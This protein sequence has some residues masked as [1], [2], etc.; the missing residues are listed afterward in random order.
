MKSLPGIDIDII[1]NIDRA[2]PELL[3]YINSFI[4]KYN[5][6]WDTNIRF[7]DLPDDFF[8]SIES[9]MKEA[10]FNILN[11]ELQ[12]EFYNFVNYKL[13][14]IKTKKEIDL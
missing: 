5:E 10:I 12:D 3:M 1:F 14:Q 8:E 13:N 11:D 6:T 2:N 7:E 9:Y 4:N